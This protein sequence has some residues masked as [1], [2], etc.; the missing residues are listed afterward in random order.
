[1]A[2]IQA[3]ASAAGLVAGIHASAGKPGKAMAEMG[4]RM[5]TLA[6]E[7]QALRRGAAEHLEG[8][9]VT[10]SDRVA[11]V[12]GAARGQGAAIVKRLRD[13]GFR[14]AACDLLVDELTASVDALGD[15][16]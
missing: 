16:P 14:V 9:A 3:A 5:I 7:S 12:T 8:G 2:R 15:A 11:L 6:S 4:F 10:S 13:D 1:M